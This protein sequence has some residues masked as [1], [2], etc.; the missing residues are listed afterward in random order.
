MLPVKSVMIVDD[1]MLM[2]TV[3]KGLVE[4]SGRYRVVNTSENGQRALE[5][6]RSQEP[7]IILLDIEMPVMDGIEFLRHAR[8]RTRARIVVL[9]SVAGA[10]APRALEARRLG[11]DAVLQKPS[12][13]VSVDVGGSLGEDL[14]K[15]LERICP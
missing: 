4:S 2:R 10:G 1:A 15:T 9:S 8:L 11:A 13:S 6:I 3:I 5:A 12:G 14:L 7:D